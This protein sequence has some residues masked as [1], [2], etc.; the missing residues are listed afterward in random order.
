M[1]QKHT[2]KLTGNDADGWSVSDGI[3][4]GNGNSP[5][6]ALDAFHE[7]KAFNQAKYIPTINQELLEA[8][9]GMMIAVKKQR[10]IINSA[11][12]ALELSFIVDYEIQAA[13]VIAKA[14]GEQI[15][16]DPVFLCD[17]NKKVNENE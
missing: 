2:P 11:D 6:L 7:D 14:E 3:S 15:E 17:D 16:I 1:T 5:Q 10:G 8:L 4:K 13:K 12:F 9:K